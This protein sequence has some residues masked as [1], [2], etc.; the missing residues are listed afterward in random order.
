LEKTN[1]SD[2]PVS[3]HDQTK[4]NQ[5]QFL[6]A[7]GASAFF[8]CPLSPF[9]ALPMEQKQA[10]FANIMEDEAE[11]I[12]CGITPIFHAISPKAHT[13]FLPNPGRLATPF[14]EAKRLPINS[15]ENDNIMN[16]GSY[17]NFS[18]FEKGTIANTARK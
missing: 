16:P 5:Q 14:D 1:P 15:V 7:P 9:S 17:T 18:F 12:S 13:P 3:T 10:V 8:Q 6:M 11:S 2:R 4:Y